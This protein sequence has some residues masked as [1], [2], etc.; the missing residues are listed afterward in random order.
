[1]VPISRSSTPPLNILLDSTFGFSILLV[2]K[3]DH[4]SQIKRSVP[5]IIRGIVIV[6]YEKV[7]V[8]DIPSVCL[9]G[10]NAMGVL[11]RI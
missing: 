2:A 6:L 7:K 11:F 3:Y 1:M 4:R 9:V 8:W 10:G 5:T